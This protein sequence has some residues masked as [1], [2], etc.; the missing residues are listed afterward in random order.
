MDIHPVTAL[1]IEAI[2]VS[3][4]CAS[5][6]A[7]DGSARW[8]TPEPA[9]RAITRWLVDSVLHAGAAEAALYNGVWRDPTTFPR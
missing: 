6:D 1:E 3:S 9:W 8:P 5:A 7:D 2:A 4:S